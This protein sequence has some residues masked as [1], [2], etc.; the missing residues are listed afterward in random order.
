MSNNTF[1]KENTADAT[2][3]GYTTNNIC[4]FYTDMGD[5]YKYIGNLG[6][7][8]VRKKKPWLAA[9]TIELS[10]P[11]GER[12][13]GF[14]IP[15]S[16]VKK[17]TPLVVGDTLINTKQGGEFYVENE[18]HAKTLN[19]H[20]F[21]FFNNIFLVSFAG[22][23]NTGIQ[24]VGDDVIVDVKTSLRIKTSDADSVNW[25]NMTRNTI[26]KSWKPNHAAVR[27][28]YQAEQTLKEGDVIEICPSELPPG[29]SPQLWDV[30]AVGKGVGKGEHLCADGEHK[31]KKPGETPAQVDE[32]SDS[33]K[34]GNIGNILHNMS[35][36]MSDDEQS[37]YGDY[38]SYCWELSKQLN[39]AK[40]G[41]VE[42]PVFTKEMKEAN[43]LPPIG[44]ECQMHLNDD[45]GW[46]NVFV[47]GFNSSGSLVVQEDHG[48][49][50][51]NF[52]CEYRPIDSRTDEEK[53]SDAIMDYLSCDA[54]MAQRIMFAPKFTITLNKG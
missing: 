35:C 23:P 30:V 28:Q 34:I 46:V 49:I 16:Y 41:A 14:L 39:Q 10:R 13:E 40:S 53:L 36:S 43:L 2:H 31:L 1:T 12:R 6:D 7:E 21:K 17:F 8:G 22:R 51:T 29:P 52:S 54:H 44:S 32:N 20:S 9:N 26:M 24:P 38:A 25:D 4:Y 48:R 15:I 47:V 27:K 18:N 3:F 45:D 11:I 19:E 5:Q 42:K 37:E 50:W 33:C